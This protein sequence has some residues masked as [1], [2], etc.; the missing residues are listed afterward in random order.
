[1]EGKEISMFVREYNVQEYVN[2]NLEVKK[3][4]IVAAAKCLRIYIAYC[5]VVSGSISIVIGG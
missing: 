3:E 5:S 4:S 2:D 1:M